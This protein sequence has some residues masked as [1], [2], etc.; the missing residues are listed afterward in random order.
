MIHDSYPWKAE[1]SRDAAVIERWASKP[2]FSERRSFLIERKVFLAA[3]AMRK[4]DDA[5]MV[6]SDR[7]ARSISVVRFPSTRDGYSDINNHR[8][9][10][11]FDL[12][13]PVSVDLRR[14]RLLDLLIH[15]GHV[16]LRK[17]EGI[18]RGESRRFC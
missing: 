12:D 10:E 9:R 7:F 2:R 18:G 15:Y 4:L 14:R 8:Y 1:L 6:S 5:T 16:G 17:G 3:Y 13:A 11:F